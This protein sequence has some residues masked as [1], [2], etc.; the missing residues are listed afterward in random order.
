MCFVCVRVLVYVVCL[1]MRVSASHFTADCAA[2]VAERGGV[3]RSE[4]DGAG[5]SAAHRWRAA[6]PVRKFLIGGASRPVHVRKGKFYVKWAIW[7]TGNHFVL[8]SVITWRNCPDQ[9]DLVVPQDS[10]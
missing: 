2:L 8:C 7:K 4:P 6:H 10:N 5:S 3:P 1:C 9:F